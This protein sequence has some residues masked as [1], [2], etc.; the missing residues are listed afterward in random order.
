MEILV[1]PGGD[2]DVVDVI[3]VNEQGQVA[4]SGDSHPA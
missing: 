1:S 3:L 2:R 4:S